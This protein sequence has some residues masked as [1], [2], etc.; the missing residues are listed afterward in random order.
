A[1]LADR[2]QASADV[3]D[4]IARW[5]APVRR[6]GHPWPLAAIFLVCGAWKVH[7]LHQ[8]YLFKPEGLWAGYI[9]IWGDWAAHLTFAGSFAYG[10]NFPPQYPIDPGNNLG[11]PFMVDF[12]AANL[13]P[14]GSSLTTALVLTSG[15][16][17][18]A[19]PVVLYLAAVRFAGGRAAAAIAVFVFLLS[20][21]LGF[22]YL[23]GDIAHGGIGVLAH[24]PREYT[25]NRDL[26]FQGLAPRLAYR[27]PQRPTLFGFSLALIVLLLVWLAAR[28][29]RGWRAFLFA[30]VVAGLMPAFHVHAFGTVVALS[31]FWAAFNLRRE[32]V[33]FF[34]PALALSIPV[35]VWMWPHANN[36]YCSG[37]ASV[38]GYCLEAGWLSYTDSQRDGWIFFPVDFV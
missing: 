2:D 38:A 24:L 12:L 27:L 14:L 22:Y 31:A 15:L 11:Y 1:A 26:S 5:S 19:F 32:W 3:V 33:M 37:G 30:G 8:A 16:L 4:A 9:N 10:H 13:V 6:A 34:I 25:L 28:E 23:F 35:L 20:G 17:G 29:H 36:S 7:F 21:G 18:L